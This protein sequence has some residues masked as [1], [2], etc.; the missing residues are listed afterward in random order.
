MKKVISFLVCVFMAS[1]IAAQQTKPLQWMLSVWKISTP[2]GMMM[3]IWEQKDDS[4]LKGRSV[5]V[6]PNNDTI[7]QE[8]IEMVF[9]NGE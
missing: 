8:N 2:Q 3:E 6:K 5:F 9:R 4:T 7:P 1:Q